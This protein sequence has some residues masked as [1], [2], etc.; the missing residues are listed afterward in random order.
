MKYFLIA[1]EASGDMHGAKLMAEI[2]KVDA[3]AEF[4]FFGGDLMKDQGGQL[5]KHYRDLAFMGI[6]P[7]VMNI[8]A[9][10]RN[11]KQCKKEISGFHPDVLILIDYPGFNLRMA[12]YAKK[13]R[14]RTVYYI[15]PKI[16]AWKTKRVKK[17]K[18]DVDHMFTIFPFET[19]FYK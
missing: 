5:I 7:V 2:K 1:G 15:S 6:I 3:T 14:I 12:R 16:W 17:V 9:V 18:K 8:G 19:E 13:N 11:F 4:M 10:L